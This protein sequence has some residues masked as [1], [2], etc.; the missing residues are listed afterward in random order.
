M[1]C[2][3]DH[4]HCQ[5]FDV[6]DLLSELPACSG[7]V[8][9]GAIIVFQIPGGIDTVILCPNLPTHKKN[10][11]SQQFKKKQQKKTTVNKMQEIKQCVKGKIS[12][13][14]STKCL[15]LTL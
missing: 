8:F 14:Y 11:Q 4:S 5:D 9:K 6:H 1:A 3:Y 7:V 2:H 12:Y 10:Q 15:G 13:I